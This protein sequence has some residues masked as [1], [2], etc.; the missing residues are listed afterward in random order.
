MDD[1]IKCHILKYVKL[2]HFTYFRI[3]LPEDENCFF[4]KACVTNLL[5]KND[6]YYGSCP[7]I[8]MLSYLINFS[9]LSPFL[10]LCDLSHSPLSSTPG[11]R[12]RAHASKSIARSLSGKR[13]W[14]V[15]FSSGR[16]L[17]PLSVILFFRNH[18]SSAKT[19][20]LSFILTLLE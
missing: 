15:C 19:I 14:T 11:R 18:W 10:P 2:L 6:F 12:S 9:H 13:N 17:W 5:Q 1:N 16:I 20:R 3:I 4:F 8:H 7:D